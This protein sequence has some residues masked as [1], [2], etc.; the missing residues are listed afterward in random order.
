MGIWRNIGKI[1]ILS[2][3]IIY[4]QMKWTIHSWKKVQ[5][6]PNLEKNIDRTTRSNTTSK[7]DVTFI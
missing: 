4:Q 3:E 6:I 5:R 2:C 1:V 7:D